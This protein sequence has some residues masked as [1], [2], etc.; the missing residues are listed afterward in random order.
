MGAELRAPRLVGREAEAGRIAAALARP[1][2]VVVIEGEPGIGK[3]RLVTEALAAQEATGHRV[4]LAMCP[5]FRQPYTLGALV[6]AVRQATSGTGVREL[7]LSALA[8]ALRPLFPEWSGALPPAPEP[9]EDATAARHRLF[10]ALA[11]LLARLRVTVLVIEDVHW[12]DEATLEFALFLA[13]QAP[14][15]LSLV[16]TCRREDTAATSL[17]WRLPSRLPAGVAQLRL[18]L[19]PLDVAATARLVSSM[20]D[21]RPVSR[22]FAAFLHRSTEGVPLAVEESVRLLNDRAD[23]TRRGGEWIRRRLDQIVVPPTV[24]DAVLERA[25]RLT[26]DAQAVLRA[27]AVLGAPAGEATLAAAAGLTAARATGGLTQALACGLLDEDGRLLVSFRHV[28]AAQAVYEAIPG[29]DRRAAHLRCGHA[30]EAAVPPPLA[31][32]ARHFREAGATARWCRYGEQAADLAL[33]SG[34]GVTAAALLHDLITGAGLPAADVPRLTKKIP[35]ASLADPAQYSDLIG[36]LQNVLAGGG[37]PAGLEAEL[38]CQLGRIQ[39]VMGDFAGGRAEL[40]RAIPHLGHDPAEA[41]RAMVY[42]GWPLDPAWPAVMHRG[43]LR[44]AVTAMAPLE[45]PVYRSLDMDRVTALLILGEEEGWA[46]AARIPAQ[47]PTPRERLGV[48]RGNLN[49]GDQAMVWGR[50]AEARRRLAT[51]LD[52]AE[53]YAYP[54]VRDEVLTTT[55]HLDW[56]TGEWAGLAG[57]AAALADSDLDLSVQF[58]T[59]LVAGLLHGAAGRAAEA[60]SRLRLVIEKIGRP[61]AVQYWAEPAG[62][63]ARLRLAEGRAA[64]ALA[65]TDEPIAMVAAK[66]IWV[67]AGD[68]V[69]ARVS[70]LL[71]SGRR[72]EAADLVE[73][74]TRGLRGRD[75]P[76]PKAALALCRALFAQAR[77]EYADAATLFARAAA[78]WQVL[79]RPYDSLLASEQ[80]AHCLLAAGSRA[81]G[82]AL[83]AD[84]SEELAKLGAAGDA[85]RAS[86]AVHAARA[87][88]RRGSRRGY[89]D[90]LSPRELEVVRLVSEGLTNREIAQALS[91]SP[92][93]VDTQ[94]RSAMRKLKVSTRTALAVKAIE[95]GAVPAEHPPSTPRP[96]AR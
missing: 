13:A 37:L 71:A 34:D 1:P 21:D 46:Q 43:W 33:A 12:A 32:L 30:L 73:M 53:T 11:E 17:L 9:A 70:A 86:H 51:A 6:D 42:L 54:R 83:L 40:E 92:N 24:R 62:A 74:F 59:I 55:V 56:F 49:V 14:P 85:Q 63:L 64:D 75:A 69:P 5:P 82:L 28:L 68:L 77:G 4:L 58:E 38:R 26:P 8:G 81:A 36:V 78:A 35:F 96:A 10:R 87:P 16:L 91:R 2:A 80:Q 60:E 67:W 44:R 95:A 72:E 29:P 19:A 23:M 66:G 90:R 20:V 7:G 61:V 27:A 89:G 65:V 88:A 48:T 25:G 94:L 22:E 50:Y 57:R 52:L 18:A 47:A 41:A 39:V 31:R 84:V 76:A 3:T 93:T 45:P 15:Q 79:P